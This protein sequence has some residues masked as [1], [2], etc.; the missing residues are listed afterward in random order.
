M[1]DDD[2]HKLAEDIKANDL[3]EPIVVYQGMILDGQNRFK[4]CQISGRSAIFEEYTGA[5]PL[6]FVISKNLTRRHLTESQRAMLGSRITNQGVSKGPRV[7]QGKASA[8]FNVSDRSIRNANTV[9]NS[10]DDQLVKRVESGEITVTV[11]AKI[12]KLDD[13]RRKVVLSDARPDRAIKKV[14]RAVKE[15]ELADQIKDLPSVQFGLILAD[16]PWR[17]DVY[18]ENGMDRSAENHYPTLN[19]ETICQLDVPSISA[20][21]CILFLW[22]TAPMLPDA[23]KVMQSWGFEYKTNFIWAKDRIGTGYWARNRH[24]LLLVG[25]KGNVPAPSMGEQWPSLIDAPVMA[26]SEKPEV[27]FELIE[28]YFPTLPKIELNRR[29]LPRPSWAAWGLEFEEDAHV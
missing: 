25:T 8:I 18:S 14:A 6:G 5:D 15:R 28:E 3:Q 20:P 10:N 12:A 19:T 23:L 1:P 27:F 29:G 13:D 24:E 26:H 21:D 7:T 16:P 22:A 11:A 2:L 17:F 9:Y 4:A